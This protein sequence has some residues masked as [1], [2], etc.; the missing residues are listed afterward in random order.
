MPCFC[1]NPLE[2]NTQNDCPYWNLSPW[3]LRPRERTRNY[4]SGS[5]QRPNCGTPTALPADCQSD[6]GGGLAGLYALMSENHWPLV[7][8]RKKPLDRSW[9]SLKFS[10][11]STRLQ[12]HAQP[13]VRNPQPTGAW[14]RGSPDPACTKQCCEVFRRACKSALQFRQHPSYAPARHGWSELNPAGDH[15]RFGTR[16]TLKS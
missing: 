10:A 11:D 15:L 5:V 13:C 16:G 6:S 2:G 1:R 7:A 8:Q 14:L 3:P 12:S 9:V 4:V